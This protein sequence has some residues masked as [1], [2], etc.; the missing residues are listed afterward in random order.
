MNTFTRLAILLSAAIL[1]KTIAPLAHAEPQARLAVSPERYTIDFDERGGRTQSLM[2][3]NLSDEPLTVKLSVANW[4]LDEQNRVK[5]IPPAEDSLDQWL[6]VNPLQVT[7]PPDSPQTIRWAIL[8]RK[9]PVPGE[10][11]AL[12]YVE[13]VLPERAPQAN[14]SLRFN[15]RMGIPIY[16]HFGEQVVDTVALARTNNDDDSA[17]SIALQNKGNSHAR[18]Q[19]RYGIWPSAEFPGRDKALAALRNTRKG[20]NKKERAFTDVAMHDVVLLPDNIRYVTVNPDLP[21]SG[22]YTVQF[23]ANFGDEQLQDTVIVRQPD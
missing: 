6:V 1:A 20:R 22:E 17:V 7:I 9:Q 12:I 13:E 14:A 23:D 3:K 5:E 15:M 19:G 4:D 18:L 8:P 11:R 2:I 21:R 10:Y 16:A